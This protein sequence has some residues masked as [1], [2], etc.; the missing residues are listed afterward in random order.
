M[1]FND[2]IPE[3]REWNDGKGIGIEAWVGCTGNFQLAVGYSVVFWPQFVEFEGYVLRKGFSL[4][5]LRG[6]E[7]Q[8]H[9]ERRPVEAVMNHLHIADIQ[10]YGCE[11]LTRER[12]VYLG[13]VLKE[14][15]QVKLAWQFPSKRFEVV[16]QDDDSED[17]LDY[18]IT[19]FQTEP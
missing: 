8:N 11:D 16:F 5:S 14:I 18:Q 7:S 13:G 10:R 2:L 3:M 12:V 15:Y 9:G 6:F 1:D 4:D 19:F 17:L